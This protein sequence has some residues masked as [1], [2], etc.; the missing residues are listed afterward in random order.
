MRTLL[1][2]PAFL[3]VAAAAACTDSNPSY[4]DVTSI[5][6]VMGPGV[7]E[8]VGEE[9]YDALEP[10][11]RTVTDERTFTVT[12]QDP[13]APEWDNLKRFRQ[14]LLVG[15]RDEPW[16]QDA[17]NKV[18]GGVS[19]PGVYHA[20]DIWA[21]GQ[22]ATIIIAAAG[23]EAAAVRANLEEINAALDTQFREYARTR[24][25]LSGRDSSLADTLTRTAGF[26]VLLPR[27]YR[28]TAQDSIY[29][30]RNDNPDPAE[31]IRQVTVTWRSPIPTTFAREDILD[32]RAHVA[33][34]FSEPQDVDL[35]QADTTSFVY[36][37]RPAFQVQALWK[38]PPDLDWPAAGPFITRAVVCPPQDRLYLLDAWLYAPGKEKYEYMIQLQTILDSFRC[39]AS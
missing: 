8:D 32:W 20:Y 19:G 34:T 6:A 31:L 39:G 23:Q 3:L 18:A 16:I 2:T 38:N 26:R 11:I 9:V 27:V 4:G 24:M 12:W 33:A 14:L 36:E 5:I 25:Y 37:G 13:N 1:R 35:S 22:Q 28:W 30:F 29:S 15:T 7:W 10:T 21:R 17:V